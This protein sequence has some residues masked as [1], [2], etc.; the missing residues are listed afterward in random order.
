MACG[1][2][3]EFQKLTTFFW[4]SGETMEITLPVCKECASSNS[5]GRNASDTTVATPVG[6]QTWE[7]VYRFAV[8]EV[9]GLKMPQRISAARDAIRG[10]LGEMEG[11][12]DHHEERGRL[13]HALNA[14]KVLATESQAW[15]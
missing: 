15:R 7:E 6:S 8:L 12:S 14:L 2:T 11:D 4:E 13:E 1:L 5:S 3:A 9:D 10:R